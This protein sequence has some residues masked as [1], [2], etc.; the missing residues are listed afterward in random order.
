MIDVFAVGVTN[1][2]LLLEIQACLVS[3]TVIPNRANISAQLDSSHW[4]CLAEQSPKR[5]LIKSQVFFLD[6]HHPIVVPFFEGFFNVFLGV[7]QGF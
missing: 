4:S 6:D 1:F 2:F 7:H 5:P 3:C